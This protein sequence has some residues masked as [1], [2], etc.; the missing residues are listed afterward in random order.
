M[1][2]L[3]FMVTVFRDARAAENFVENGAMEEAEEEEEEEEGGSALPSSST[4]RSVKQLDPAL[5]PESSDGTDELRTAKR[6]IAQLEE[7]LARKCE[8]VTKLRHR[9]SRPVAAGDGVEW[10]E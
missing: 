3:R 2:M 10:K 4:L 6:K 9:F 7:R 5:I 8:E 1:V